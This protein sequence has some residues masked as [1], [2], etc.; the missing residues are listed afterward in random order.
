MQPWRHAKSAARR[1]GGAW[2]DY[3]DIH[4]FLD[5]SKMACVDLRHRIVLHNIDF[6]LALTKMAFPGREHCADIVTHHLREDL[7]ET[8]LLEEWLQ[9]ADRPLRSSPRRPDLDALVR[10]A[11][12][13]VGLDDEGPVRG[14]LDLLLSPA[15]FCRT[16][17]AFAE[18]L[19]MNSFGPVL[20][21]R[22][23]GP[24]RA[25]KRSDGAETIFDPSWVAEGLIVAHFGR[26]PSLSETLIP[27]SG[28]LNQ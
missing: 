19:L 17:S 6:G 23:L 28:R 3:L 14:V 20:V 9:T 26:I 13:T 15:R 25:I 22:M 5:L 4:E 10:A 1:L 2:Q 18:S 27:F 24:A 16:N 11:A 7:G 12:E 8:P 21:R